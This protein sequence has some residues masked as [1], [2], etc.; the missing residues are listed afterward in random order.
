VDAGIEDSLDRALDRGPAQT[1]ANNNRIRSRRLVQEPGA[2]RGRVSAPITAIHAAFA[3]ARED[4]GITV[5]ALSMPGQLRR[6]LLAEGQSALGDAAADVALLLIAYQ[7]LHSPWALSAVLLADR[8][9]RMVLAPLAGVL[10]DRVSRRTCLITAD[11][12]RA[13]ALLGLVLVHSFPATVVFAAVLGCGTALYRPV[14][15]ASLPVIASGRDGAARAV[16]SRW[17]VIVIGELLGWTLA[18]VMLLIWPPSG[19]LLFDA[20]TFAVS[21]SILTRITSLDRTS[22]DSTEVR[23][24]LDGTIKMLLDGSRATRDIPGI[25]I[26]FVTVLSAILAGGLMNVGD[27]LLA[28]NVLHSGNAGFGAL[29][30]TIGLGL[31]LG[32][33]LSGPRGRPIRAMRHSYFRALGLAAVGIAVMAAA[34]SLAIAMVGSVILG[35]GNGLAVARHL[36]LI[37]LTVPEKLIGRINGLLNAAEAG[38]FVVAFML[39]GAAIVLLGVRETFALSALGLLVAAFVGY[40]RM[41]GIRA[42]PD[43]AA[44]QALPPTTLGAV[45]RVPTV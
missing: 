4:V 7:R 17:T 30:A 38:A 8:L 31:V 26:L 15:E 33:A 39:G 12:L 34:P 28:R 19:V 14:V 29:K 10:A 11:V 21:V 20:A 5:K 16:T 6:L 32:T 1:E 18:G 36:Q 2:E 45:D 13:G 41:R 35:A 22:D 37:Q 43:A 27:P 24:E 42:E 25:L 44:T 9:P 3:A 40:L 23:E